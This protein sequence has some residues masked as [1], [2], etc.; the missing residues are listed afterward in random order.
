[1]DNTVQIAN[2][3]SRILR[4]ALGLG[5]LW[6]AFSYDDAQ[7]L[8]FFGA[9]VFISGFFKPKRCTSNSCNL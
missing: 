6:L 2:W 3:V 5:F 1:M 9:V 7:V 4:W 8:Y